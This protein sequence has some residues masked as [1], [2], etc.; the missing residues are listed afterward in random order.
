MQKMPT[1]HYFWA[2]FPRSVEVILALPSLWETPR[3]SHDLTIMIASEITVKYKLRATSGTQTF[4]SGI[5][6]GSTEWSQSSKKC[7]A[8]IQKNAS[9]SSK[10]WLNDKLSKKTNRYKRGASGGIRTSQPDGEYPSFKSISNMITV[11]KGPMVSILPLTR[12]L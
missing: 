12:T 6:Q 10:K 3:K 1:H 4:G 8:I 2:A 9:R 7:L 11:C 5:P